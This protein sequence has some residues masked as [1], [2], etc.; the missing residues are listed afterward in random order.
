MGTLLTGVP[1]MTWP[2]L[3]A[4]FLAAVVTLLVLAARQRGPAVTVDRLE[5]LD[6]QNR[7]HAPG[8]LLTVH[9]PRPTRLTR[10]GKISLIGTGAVL[11]VALIV[12]VIV[13][14]E[15]A[16]ADRLEREGVVTEAEV[17]RKWESRSGRRTRLFVSYRFRAEGN[18]YTTTTQLPRD[19]WQRVRAGDRVPVR[20]AR[21][22]PEV[23]RLA[24]KGGGLPRWALFVVV[25]V[26]ILVL[27]L[28][29]RPLLLQRRLVQSGRPAPGVV[30]RVSPTKGGRNVSYVFLDTAGSEV[31][32]KTMAP[33][34]SG[35]LP[36]P[37][38]TITVLFDPGRPS[39]NSLYPARMVEIKPNVI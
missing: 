24:A 23:N 22:S 26:A 32:G 37:K 1:G 19:Q 4:G 10:H 7:W 15:L 18:I 20:Y 38:Q 17:L 6:L 9:I 25:G 30:S 35:P 36:E 28:V 11:A 33:F 5:L 34:F 3:A 14:R 16:R 12:T 21:T 27:W 31:S 29:S 39:R 8:E 2:L 13:L